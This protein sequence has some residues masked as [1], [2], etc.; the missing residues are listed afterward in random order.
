MNNNY[1]NYPSDLSQRPVRQ[2]NWEE[3]FPDAIIR[4]LMKARYDNLIEEKESLIYEKKDNEKE[5]YLLEKT[6]ESVLGTNYRLDSKIESID[7]EMD[8]IATTPFNARV[9]MDSAPEIKQA[10]QKVS[11]PISSPQVKTEQPKINNIPQPVPK[12]E[13][14]P[15]TQKPVV[16]FP[17]SANA[18]ISLAQQLAIAKDKEKEIRQSPTATVADI[19]ALQRIINDLET[20]TKPA[21]TAEKKPEVKPVEKIIEKP[22]PQPIP[23]KTEPVKINQTPVESK[24]VETIP[25]T[26]ATFAAAEEPVTPT[27][28]KVNPISTVST[29]NN[30]IPSSSSN[31]I[32]LENRLYRTENDIIE[33]LGIADKGKP[34]FD[35]G[36]ADFSQLHVLNAQDGGLYLVYGDVDD[37]NNKNVAHFTVNDLTMFPGLQEACDMILMDPMPR[38]F[39]V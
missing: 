28:P 36:S 27:I 6:L 12:H 1:A 34:I 10:P 5:K 39:A 20:K 23:Q 25:E 19:A 21:E 22:K 33:A 16:N 7:M 29:P 37:V 13:E 31:N 8:K 3:L 30:F 14:K 38:S 24:P 17:F 2:P 26:K 35:M 15:V 9:E 4:S 32:T 11:T 18:N